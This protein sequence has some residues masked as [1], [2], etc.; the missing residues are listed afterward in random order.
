MPGSVRSL[1]VEDMPESQALMFL[2]KQKAAHLIIQVQFKRTE[3]PSW[4]LSQLLIK[5]FAFVIVRCFQFPLDLF[6]NSCL[7][8]CDW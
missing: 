3:R 2:R 6:S 7:F 4:L 5:L 8:K 1:Y